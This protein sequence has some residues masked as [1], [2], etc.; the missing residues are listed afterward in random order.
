MERSYAALLVTAANNVWDFPFLTAAIKS[1]KSCLQFLYNK[2]FLDKFSI[3]CPWIKTRNRSWPKNHVIISYRT[4]G[5]IYNILV[6]GFFLPGEKWPE[7]NDN[8]SPLSIVVL[9]NA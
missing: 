6:T 4:C 8:I 5:Y 7:R 1:S 2:Q 9:K 3:I